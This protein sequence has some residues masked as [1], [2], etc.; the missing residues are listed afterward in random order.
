M[1]YTH[2]PVLWREIFGFID[3]SPLEGKGTLVDCTL[4]EGGHSE[5]ILERFDKITI[6]AFERDREILEIAKQRLERFMERIRF[7]N[8]NFSEISRYLHQESAVVEYVLYDFGISSYH[9]DRSGRGFSFAGDEPLDMRLN[10]GDM[11][12][13]DVV[14]GFRE[15]ELADIFYTLGEERWSRKIARAIVH[16]RQG[17][18]FETTGDLAGLILR[19]VPKRYQ[20]KNIHPATRVFQA[21]RIFVNGELDAI[22]KSLAGLPGNVAPGGRVM[23]VSFHSLEDRIVKNRFRRWS[24]GCVCGLDERHCMCAGP[25]L[26][27]ILTKKP[28]IPENDEI[29]FNSRSRS[30]RLRVCERVA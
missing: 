2:I 22:E 29:E 11:T 15:K 25:A 18:K 1:N 27:K 30:A 6:I 8:D 24:K 9:F 28:I 26:V 21:L 23:A 19:V 16:D 3:E 4:G 5:K 13:A 7:I 10:G 17:K 12:A 20:V 14:N